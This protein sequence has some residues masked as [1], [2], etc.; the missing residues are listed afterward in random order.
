MSKAQVLFVYLRGFHTGTPHFLKVHVTSL[1]FH[2]KPGLVPYFA[3]WKKSLLFKGIWGNVCGLKSGM[4]IPTTSWGCQCLIGPEGQM[5][6]GWHCRQ[7]EHSRKK[8]DGSKGGSA[9]Q[10]FI[11]FPRVCRHG[12]TSMACR[13][14]APHPRTGL[15]LSRLFSLLELTWLEPTISICS[16]LHCHGFSS[17]LFSL[18]QIVDNCIFFGHQSRLSALRHISQWTGSRRS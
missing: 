18:Q 5:G 10:C 15:I 4:Y 14:S 2:K 7:W 12:V 9:W 17:L 11:P 8:S 6:V 1:C 13:H 16:L 3:N